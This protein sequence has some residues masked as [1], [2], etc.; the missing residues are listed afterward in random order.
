MHEWIIECEWDIVDYVGF[1]YLIKYTDGT[2]YI[3]K[4]NFWVTNEMQPL[5]DGSKRNGHLEFVGRRKAGKNVKMEVVRKESNWKT[6]SGS[7]VYSKGKTISSKYILE[8]CETK[9]DL[10]FWETSHII[11]SRALFD[12]SYLNM[13]CMGKFYSGQ[14]TGSKE[15]TKEK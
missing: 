12:D 7:T 8:L 14:L 1:V 13:N 9:I 15:Y 11:E 5:K 2:K 6:Y 10:T 4:K 3:G